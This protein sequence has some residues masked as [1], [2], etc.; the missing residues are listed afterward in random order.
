MKL[1]EINDAIASACDVRGNVVSAVQNET[2][3][4]IKAQLDK[5][6]KV[7]I[8][9]FGIFIVKDV[10]AVGDVPAKRS[11]RFREKSGEGKSKEA[12]K[13]KGAENASE[14]EDDGDDE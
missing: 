12:R 10:P 9:D 5:G 6:E 3:R 14:P 13:N 7:I 4:Q 2:F 11:V 1:K 8:P